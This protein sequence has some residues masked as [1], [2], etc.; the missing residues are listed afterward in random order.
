MKNLTLDPALSYGGM[1]MTSAILMAGKPSV[2]V[3]RDLENHI[4]ASLV[5]RLGAGLHLNR[6]PAARLPALL[7]KV[8]EQPSFK[9]AAEQFAATH[10]G[11]DPAQ[12]S[13][14]ILDSMS[15]ILAAPSPKKRTRKKSIATQGV[16]S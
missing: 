9:R 1:G 14:R 7:A 4:N 10:A 3:T 11:H 16:T 2:Y 6:Y 5:D 15:E 8:M 12:L 13:T